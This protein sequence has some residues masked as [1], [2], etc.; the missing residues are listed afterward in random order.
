M[1]MIITNY[2]LRSSIDEGPLP[3]AFSLG[4]GLSNWEEERTKLASVSFILIVGSYLH[5]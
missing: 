2:Y 4:F 1:S 5:N 3:F